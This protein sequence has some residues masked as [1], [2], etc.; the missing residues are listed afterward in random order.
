MTSLFKR[1]PKPGPQ[2]SSP[3]E[4]AE[5]ANLD[6]KRSW[7]RRKTDQARDTG[8]LEVAYTAGQRLT[9]KL[10]HLG[11][12][13]V[14]LCGPAGLL[15]AISGDASV[16][17]AVAEPPVGPTAQDSARAGQFA[18][19]VV[20]AWLGATRSKPGAIADLYRGAGGF[21]FPERATRVDQTA[22]AGVAPTGVDQVLSVT[23]AATAEG[24]LRYYAIPV[25]VTASGMAALALPAPV[26]PPVVTLAKQPAYTAVLAPN[27]PIGTATA[28]FLGALVAGAGD[29]SRYVT[30]GAAI[31]AVTPAPY[32]T[33]SV[34]A[35]AA[36]GE[37]QPPDE[38]AEAQVQVTA[39]GTDTAKWQITIQIALKLTARAGR[40]EVTTIDLAPAA[41]PATRST[42]PASPTTTPR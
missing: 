38:G 36:T 5:S 10:A 34:R 22:L 19:L 8:D 3:G 28:A 1:T 4:V 21:V 18:Q 41:R 15:V 39:I 35:I 2:G 9:T 32:R 11:A 33:V 25:E 6:K 40:W 31:T 20:R 24:T 42:P 26:P 23:V 12:A 30:P 27:G 16:P 13:A 7:L 17:Q 37:E 14:V 29:V